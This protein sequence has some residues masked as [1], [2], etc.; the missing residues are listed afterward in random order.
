MKLSIRLV[1]L[2]VIAAAALFNIPRTVQARGDHGCSYRTVAGAF[3]DVTTGT[4]IGVGP[5]ASQ[6][7]LTFVEDGTVEG[8][9]TASFNGTIV[10]ETYTGTYVVDEGCSGSFTVVVTSSIPAFNRTSTVNL[11]W[12][13]DARAAHAI[14][15]SPQTVL[16]ADA[17]RVFGHD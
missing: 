7:V 14:F 8:S 9:Q 12:E 17:R 13:D 16:T 4:R 1:G 5:V 2:A 3:G 15:T 6:G 10:T 11:V